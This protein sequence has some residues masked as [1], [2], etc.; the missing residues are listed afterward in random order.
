MT[1]LSPTFKHI[2]WHHATVTRIRREA[3]NGHR[4]AI[5]WFTGLSG[6]GKS[7]LA[8]A[9]EEE[10]H[11]NGY[12]TFVLDG[13]NIRHGLCSDLGFT[14]EDR[15]ENIRRVGEVAK[16]FMQAGII[17]LTAFISPYRVE[18]ERV[19]GLVEHGDFIEIY[20][21]SPVEICESRDV[22][23]LYKKARAGL[24]PEFTG[25]SS[26][27]ETPLNPELIVSTGK[28]SLESCV[29]QVIDE[30]KLRGIIK[31]D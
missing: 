28:T 14:P 7:T 16:L 26:P 4:G 24:I 21:D 25:I 13:D 1:D 27:Y 30:L 17:V 12:R 10:L 2:V 9:V 23:G 3:L 11:Q 31:Q 22:K 18:R 5:L 20:C 15:I 6:A 8:H 19:R 29:Q